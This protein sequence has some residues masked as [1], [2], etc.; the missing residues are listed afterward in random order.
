[1]PFDPKSQEQV[2]VARRLMKARM[3]ANGLHHLGGRLDSRTVF[4]LLSNK[5]LRNVRQEPL[6]EDMTEIVANSVHP[7]RLSTEWGPLVFVQEEENRRV[8]VTVAELL[9]DPDARRRRAALDHVERGIGEL[10]PRTREVLK[11][12]R[13]HF[14]RSQRSQWLR[15]AVSIHDAITTDFFFNLAG[16]RQSVERHFDE[17]FNYY[18]PRVL[19][20]SLS[21]ID[22]IRPPI[23]NPRE[24]TEEIEKCVRECVQR[25][26]TLIE[27][28]DAHY[29]KCGYL[30]LA[31]TLSIPRVVT[32]WQEHSET[33]EDVWSRIWAW[34]N[35]EPDPVR[36][37]HACCVFLHEPRFLPEDAAG[38]LWSEVAK[39]TSSSGTDFDD[40]SADETWRLRC[41]L[42]SHYCQYIESILP[43]QDG[44]VTAAFAWWLAFQVADAVS[45]SVLDIQDLRKQAV[46]PFAVTSDAVRRLVH[47]PTE[48]SALRYTTLFLPSVWS[49]SLLCQ[50]GRNIE[51][52]RA[53]EIDAQDKTAITRSMKEWLPTGFHRSVSENAPVYAF[54]K[55]LASSA[56]DWITTAG[57]TAEQ[58]DFEA[59]IGLKTRAD[60]LEEL[61]DAI[62]SLAEFNPSMQFLVAI[63]LGEVV[64][65]GIPHADALWNK[66]Q[67]SKW[68]E[69]AFLQGS[70]ETTAMLC[71]LLIEAQAKASDDWRTHL[72]HFLAM[73]CESSSGDQ[74]RQQL[75]FAFVVMSSIST[76]TVSALRRLLHGRHRH[77]L[78][79]YVLVWK[80]NL[81][82][83]IETAEPWIAARMR[84]VLGELSGC[85]SS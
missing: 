68:R 77:T 49:F 57:E 30:P 26:D 81:E 1:M 70:T 52:L 17:A 45:S 31:A 73:A 84:P 72:P 22:S 29:R 67:D 80:A 37:Y 62:G 2:A 33:S 59:L 16:V 24:Q 53:T 13:E 6:Q 46:R 75:L 56:H 40:P 76:D 7:K 63:F 4:L 36:R 66:L 78:H 10:T 44:D 47:P 18:W 23:W 35:E 14:R 38:E 9:I 83:L 41:D 55:G 71:D 74:E 48:G 34:A 32:E 64:Y 28:V 60:N 82:S 58:T 27:A 54:D 50:V 43:G 25:A 51:S 15:P 11:E 3:M 85:V 20:P 65:S 21:S 61:L 79:K 69:S 42:A 12:N 5:L 39:I 8:V 19:R